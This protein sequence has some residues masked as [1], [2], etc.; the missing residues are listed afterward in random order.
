MRVDNNS[1][2]VR[3]EN[4]P[5]ANRMCEQNNVFISNT[6]ETRFL[7]NKKYYTV[8][9]HEKERT[10]RCI[11]EGGNTERGA[12]GAVG[13][14]VGVQRRHHAQFIVVSKTNTKYYKYN[15]LDGEF[16]LKY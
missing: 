16:N 10:E 14:G 8:V 12:G 11:L 2:F 5:P 7:Y 1:T 15:T 4:S 9:R 6:M 3:Y 13:E